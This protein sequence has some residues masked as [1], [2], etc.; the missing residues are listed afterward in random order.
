M[1]S[2]FHDPL[3]TRKIAPPSERSTGLV[4]AAVSMIVAIIFRNTT[5]VLVG[6][7]ALAAAFAVVSL[8]KPAILGPLNRAWFRLSLLLHRIVNPVVLLLIFVVAFVPMGFLMR[9]WRDPLMSKKRS[10][11]SS[12]WI[13]RDPKE[14]GGSMRNQF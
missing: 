4:F 11:L 12:Y 1:T 14:S 10:G 2:G 3:V 7:I 5:V 6:G 13:E 8:V 9:F